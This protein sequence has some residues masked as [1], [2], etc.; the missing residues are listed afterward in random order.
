MVLKPRRGDGNHATA[1]VSVAP[2]GLKPVHIR[3]SIQPR[4]EAL[5]YCR[6]PLRGSKVNISLLHRFPGLKPWA[7]TGRPYG[8]AKRMPSHG[9]CLVPRAFFKTDPK[10]QI[11]K[12]FPA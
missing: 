8:A 7:T 5:G 10:I 4:A 3:A 2:S 12:L 6:S 11:G 1:K 9:F